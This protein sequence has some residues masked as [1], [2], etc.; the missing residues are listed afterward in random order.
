MSSAF[1]AL[2]Q[3]GVDYG[4]IFFDTIDI[5]HLFFTFYTC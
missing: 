2:I 3:I 4:V 5:F 1:I